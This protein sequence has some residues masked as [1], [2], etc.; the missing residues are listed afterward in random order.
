[1]TR[2][3]KAQNQWQIFN[4]EEVVEIHRTTNNPIRKIKKKRRKKEERYEKNPSPVY[5]FILG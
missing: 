3:R 2:E 4:D 5:Y 1:M